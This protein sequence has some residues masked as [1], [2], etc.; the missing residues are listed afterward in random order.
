MFMTNS[1][2]L[3]VRYCFNM[4]FLVGVGLLLSPG[5]LS[6]LRSYSLFQRFHGQGFTYAMD[7][8][9]FYF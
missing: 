9:T 4:E 7:F 6:C 3:G 2:A 1:R 5:F 8:T